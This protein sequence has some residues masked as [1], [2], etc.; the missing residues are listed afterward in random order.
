[1]AKRTGMLLAYGLFVTVWSLPLLGQNDGS[2]FPPTSSPSQSTALAANRIAPE[3]EPP[4]TLKQRFFE[5]RQSTFQP[6]VVIF[7][8]IAA[9][10]S[11]MNNYPSEWKQGGEGYGKRLLSA[12]GG[13]VL[14]N[15]I[16]FGVAAFTHEDPRYIRS[17]YP[18]KAVFRRTGYALAHTFI[19]HLSSSDGKGHTLA[20]SR[21]AGAYG[22]GFIANEWYPERHSTLHNAVYLGTFNLAADLGSNVLREF[23]RPHWVWGPDKTKKEKP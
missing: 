4:L 21:V 15:T 7:P 3:T 9:G 19:S 13:V 8:A 23:I 11:Q 5:Y 20:W 17:T 2:A 18:K 12:S 6:A 1:M 22:A 10:Y 16:S 14:D